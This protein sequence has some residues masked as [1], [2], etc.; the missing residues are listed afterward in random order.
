MRQRS[1]ILALLGLASYA[2]ALT[3]Y[4]TELRYDGEFWP[5]PE[6]AEEALEA[7]LAIKAFVLERLPP[8]LA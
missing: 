4:A 7:A 8:H 3:P 5:S 1:I 6:T 2:D